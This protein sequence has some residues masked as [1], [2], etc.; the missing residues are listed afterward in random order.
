[1][2]IHQMAHAGKRSCS[3]KYVKCDVIKAMKRWWLVTIWTKTAF[4]QNTLKIKKA[5]YKTYIKRLQWIACKYSVPFFL[6]SGWVRYYLTQIVIASIFFFFLVFGVNGPL[7]C[8]WNGHNRFNKSHI[9]G[10]KKQTC[11]DP[12]EDNVD[13]NL[14]FCFP[15]T[16][17]PPLCRLLR[18]RTARVGTRSRAVYFST[19]PAKR[20]IRGN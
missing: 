14:Y 8:L 13:I 1:M 5:Q 3:K 4:Y 10:L 16:L 17:G 2:Q 6:S 12:I 15:N 20:T 19:T 9:Q 7:V 18:Y 11:K